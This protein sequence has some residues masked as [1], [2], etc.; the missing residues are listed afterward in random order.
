MTH[1][2][3]TDAPS[4]TRCYQNHHLDSTRW[5]VYSPRAG[6]I[7]VTTAYKSGTTWTQQIL[8]QLLHGE[9]DP[10]PAFDAVTPWPDARFLP[11]TRE[12]LGPFMDAIPGRRF[13]KSHLPLDGLPYYPE[14]K[15][16]IVGRDARDV[17]MSFFNHYSRYTDFA[18]SQFNA[19]DIVGAKLPR[20]PEDPRAL[21]Q[22]WI[23]RG[24]FDWE[25]E[26]WPFWANLGHTASYWPW[27]GLPN[28]H[29]MHYNDML[30]DLEGTVRSLCAFLGEAPSQA[31]LA[32]I[33]ERTT[34]RNAKAEA[35]AADAGRGRKSMVFEG[36]A[37]GF[38]FKATN[39]RWRDVLTDA[40]L[41]LYEQAKRRVLT[42]DC[43]RW[44]EVGGPVPA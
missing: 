37:G 14:V 23:T 11:I 22:Q 19:P 35:L 43:A 17:F 26:G 40:D 20:C 5:E 42:P 44:L 1:P 31:H 30:A 18:M 32:R 9:T 39:G 33:V 13:I 15:Y 25:S 10:M 16:L 12:A 27:R 38:F 8:Y 4:V 7:I 29:F 28:F 3:P 24:W 6:D 34:F 41:E 21:W 2:G 36:G